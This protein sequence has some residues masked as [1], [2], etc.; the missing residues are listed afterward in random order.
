MHWLRLWIFLSSIINRNFWVMRKLY[1]GIR[2]CNIYRC[3]WLSGDL[4]SF[5]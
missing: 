5:N 1:R 4:R 2:S 3:W